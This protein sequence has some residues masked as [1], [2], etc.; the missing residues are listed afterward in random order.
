VRQ[1]R[2]ERKYDPAFCHALV[3]RTDLKGKGEG[4]QTGDTKKRAV[5]LCSR[6]RKHGAKFT[7]ISLLQEIRGGK[8]NVTFHAR[9]VWFPFTLP[10]SEETRVT[11]RTCYVTAA[12]C[13]W[14]LYHGAIKC[15]GGGRVFLCVIPHHG[16]ALG[17]SK[18][19]LSLG[20][21]K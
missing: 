18:C 3:S 20:A 17:T 4:V 14:N 2:H 16:H 1:A 15:L 13:K 5:L 9:K 11:Q 8:F 6:D 10:V 7:R 21:G 19:T 12:L